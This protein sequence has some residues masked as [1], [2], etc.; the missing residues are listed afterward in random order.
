M[1][2]HMLESE[3]MLIVVLG[4][5]VLTGWLSSAE[6]VLTIRSAAVV[7][8]V[9]VVEG[10]NAPRAAPISWEGTRVTQA[11]NGGNFAFQGMVPAD[12]V[13]RLEDGVPADAVDVALANCAPVSSAPAPVSQTGQTTCW[14]V[15]DG[16]ISCD[17]PAGIGQ[18]G[19]IQ[20]GVAW[21]TPRFTDRGNGTV[22]DNLTG[23][24]WLKDAGCF[25][26]SSTWSQALTDANTLASGM[27][28][29][30]D[31]SHPGDWHL[32]TIHELRSLIDYNQVGPVLPAGHPFTNVFFSIGS[33]SAVYWTSTSQILPEPPWSQR[34]TVNFSNAFTL[35]FGLDNN[36]RAAVWPVR[37][38]D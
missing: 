6:A 18:D 13:G 16:Q 3:T 24:L 12:C 36:F 8:G 25:S 17:E 34:W 30:T 35:G 19:D 37:G 1:Q 21:P 2:K 22:R 10:G 5:W 32:S 7:N 28:G 9:A 11:N 38:G 27:C 33:N 14:Q 15:I 26:T 4:L 31:G 20:A 23:L 29:L